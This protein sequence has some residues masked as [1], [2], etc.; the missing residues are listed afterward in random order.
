MVNGAP[1]PH[2]WQS[3]AAAAYDSLGGIFCGLEP[4]AG[5]SFAAALIARKCR[6]PLVCAPA[7]AIPQTRKMFESYGVETYAAKDGP[8]DGA[9]AFA[10]Y[11]WLTQAA[12]AD[13]FSTFLAS[14]Y[15][16]DEFHMVRN[17]GANGRKP[18]SAGVRLER[19]LVARPATRVAVF[20]GSPMSQ[21]I[22]DFG[23]GL[24]WALRGHVRGLVPRTRSGLE[25][26]AEK[27]ELGGE[28][29]RAAF[30]AR[31]QTQP[32]VFLDSGGAGLYQGEVVLRVLRREP[33]LTLGADWR[34]PD[35][36]YLVSAAQAASVSKQ[37]AWGFWPK[38]TP[39][40]SERYLEARRTWSRVVRDV[41]AT[42][43][44]D[45][46]SQV[47]A[48]RP[49]A[50]AAYEA[51]EAAE[52][53]GTEEAVWETDL[54]LCNELGLAR[55]AAGP[56]IVW[57]HHRALQDRAAALADVPLFRE[58]ARD[59]SGTHFPDSRSALAVAS[60]Q[61]CHQSLNLQHFNHN[62]VLE[63]QADPEVM[64]QLIGRTAR[65]GQTS[66]RVT[67]DLVVACSASENAL[68]ESVARAKVIHET[69]GK[70]N[71][72]LKLEL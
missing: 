68:R 59:A 33:A 67:V 31:L 53:L 57:A 29:E 48:L 17:L 45:T 63:P 1:T 26:L 36:Y 66:P 39:R 7:S 12:Q 43:A 40:P 51:A 25:A 38:V 50:W 56:T 62:V 18:N 21:A 52:P 60:I 42:G 47:R 30:L 70:L 23:H 22:T 35:G 72:L 3:A 41:I 32:G 16:L 44:A 2:P 27:L 54:G 15:L 10:S 8:R 55:R 5:K 69:T 64:K 13:F 11:T 65:Q 49:E 6:R 24:T 20:T 46:D 34:L 71:P 58:G 61:A 28:R 9:C 14:D 4:G 19:D 37:L